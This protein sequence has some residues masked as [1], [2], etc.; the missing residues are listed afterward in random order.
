[1]IMARLYG[2]PATNCVYM[3]TCSVMM[4][5]TVGDRMHYRLISRSVPTKTMLR[6]ESVEAFNTQSQAVCDLKVSPRN[7]IPRFTQTE[8]SVRQRQAEVRRRL[9]NMNSPEPGG[10]KI[11]TKV[12]WNLVSWIMDGDGLLPLFNDRAKCDK[13]GVRG[14]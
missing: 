4:Y 6:T 12:R 7:Q 10:G 1:M 13:K 9:S 2:L 11:Q 3:C 14:T 5:M 8:A